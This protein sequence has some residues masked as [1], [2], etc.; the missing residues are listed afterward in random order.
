MTRVKV[1][2]GDTLSIGAVAEMLD[3]TPA[4]V[5]SLTARGLLPAIQTGSGW[6]RY[7]RPIVEQYLAC[8]P[9]GPK[10]NA[11]IFMRIWAK[12][13]QDG[14]GCWTFTGTLQN[15]Y[16]HMGHSPRRGNHCWMY[17]ARYGPIP[18]GLQIDH[19]C[20]NRACCNPD[21]LEAVTLA[22]NLRRGFGVSAINGRK[23]HC[24]RGHEFTPENTHRV[25]LGRNCRKCHALREAERR[26]RLKA[27][28]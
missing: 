6:R 18:E 4:R 10:H 1:F 13:E 16:G 23:T 25:P 2:K 12:V 21:H 28:S 24:I 22:E 26:A 15:G 8:H 19:L 17:E 11:P 14:S 3:T 9:I 20:R 5:R 27:A 7:S